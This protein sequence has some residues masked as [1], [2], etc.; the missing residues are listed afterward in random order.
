MPPEAIFSDYAYF[1][2]YSDS[3]LEHC[4]A[5]R[6]D[7]DR[8]RSG[9]APRRW[10]SRSRATTATCC[11]TS[12]TPGIPVL[13]VEPAANVAEVAIARGHPDRGRVLRHA[14]HARAIAASGHAADLVVANNVLAHVP[15]LER[16]RRRPRRRAEAGGRAHD[17]GAAPAAPAR[18]RRV[19]HDLPRAL[20]LLLA[21]RGPRRARAARAAG[22]RRRGAADPRRQPADVG[23]ARRRRRSAW[24]ETAAVE[25]VARRRARGG[26]RRARRLRAR[27]RRAS[28]A[29]LDE[30][31]R[32][33]RD[34]RAAGERVAAYGAAAKG[35]TL[36]NSAG[37]DR[38]RHRLRRRPQPA[39]AGPVPARLAH[40]DPRPRAR[41]PTTG[42][43]T[44]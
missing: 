26:P 11:G 24:P 42:P 12:S 9:S 38:R 2:S 23:L 27:S 35:N 4:A 16:L 21:A 39:Q 28:R 19:R 14:Q 44:C 25:R 40:P 43:T 36:L 37:V 22:L 20:L 18:A 34:A 33:L 31:R 17:R 6:A 5:L 15:D 29:L 3:W 8:A 32:F 30:L 41:A 7:G 10:W 13:G 1:S